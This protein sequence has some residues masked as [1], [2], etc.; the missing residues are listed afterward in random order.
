MFSQSHLRVQ[1]NSSNYFTNLDF[2][3]GK[4]ILNLTNDEDISA[5]TVKLEGESRTRLTGMVASRAQQNAYLYDTAPDQREKTEMEIHKV[6][7]V[8]KTHSAF[9]WT[10]ARENFLSRHNVSAKSSLLIEHYQ[11]ESIL[12]AML[13]I[14]D[15]GTLQSHYRLSIIN[16]SRRV[17]QKRDLYNSSWPT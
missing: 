16:S 10:P 4:L 11:L 12:N 9:R 5:I 6:S 2:I 1:L 14:D 7:T 8:S 3:S 13:M 17:T 15:S